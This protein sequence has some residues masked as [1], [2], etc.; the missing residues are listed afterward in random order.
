LFTGEV[1]KGERGRGACVALLVSFFLLCPLRRGRRREGWVQKLTG[2]WWTLRTVR[3]V[4]EW[5]HSH[6]NYM[7]GRELRWFFCLSDKYPVD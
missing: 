3:L 1:Q 4:A 5:I 6:F 7:N 2:G